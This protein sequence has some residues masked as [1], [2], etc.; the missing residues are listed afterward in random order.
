MEEHISRAMWRL[1]EPIH[2]VVYFHP[3]ATSSY[4][5]VGLKGGWMSYFASRSAAL[6][7]PSKEVVEALFY[8][9]APA[10]V[11]RAIPDAWNLSSP[12]LILNVRNEI[13][14]QT[15]SGGIRGTPPE[16]ELDNLSAH[17][18]EIASSLP[19]G[20]RALYA[21]HLNLHWEQSSE[22]MLF[23]AATLLRE[24]RGDTHNAA[25]A[26]HGIDGVQ[27]HLLQIA[28]GVVTHDVIFPT[29]GW[30]EDAWKDGLERL[31]SNGLLSQHSTPENPI[32]TELGRLIKQ[33]V[34]I[35]T[36][37]HSNPWTAMTEPARAHSGWPHRGNGRNR[38]PPP[39]LPNRNA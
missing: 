35:Q 6:G 33:Q 27:S 12:E 38:L 3:N 16:K 4:K 17:L 34:E 15:I 2:S 29:R 26:A 19:K 10:M 9:F 22:L 1:Y 11:A 13:A 37:N 18:L 20:G 14:M 8:H 21:A 24:H 39:S 36:D 28:A 7:T 25:L 32:L 31:M 23:G 5:A 30:S